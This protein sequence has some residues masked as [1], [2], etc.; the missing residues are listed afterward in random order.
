MRPCVCPLA[1]VA[2]PTEVEFRHA[3]ALRKDALSIFLF[4]LLTQLFLFSHRLCLRN[5][6]VFL[7]GGAWDVF[8][9]TED[10]KK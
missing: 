6:G 1:G 7:N 2:M 3:L 5:K 9:L 4:V 10:K 8:L